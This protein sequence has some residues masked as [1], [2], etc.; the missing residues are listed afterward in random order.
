VVQA[1]EEIKFD[2]LTSPWFGVHFSWSV[3]AVDLGQGQGI[4]DA[5]TVLLLLGS[6]VK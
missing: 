2:T 5:E 3:F 4:A 1:I 6:E